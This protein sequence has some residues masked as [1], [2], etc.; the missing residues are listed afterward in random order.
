MALVNHNY[1]IYSDLKTFLGFTH[2][3]TCFSRN[4]LFFMMQL[5]LHRRQEYNVLFSFDH[6]FLRSDSSSFSVP[7]Q[8]PMAE[9][10]FFFLKHVL[11]LCLQNLKL[12]FL[13][14]ETQNMTMD[15]NPNLA[16]F[17]V[18]IGI[19]FIW[20]EILTLPLICWMILK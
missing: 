15:N 17:V 7:P 13:I 20:E 10:S 16:I 8:D 18:T 11:H 5:I 12:T 6:I 2:S 4:S 14:Y 19:T 1:L 3:F 9:T